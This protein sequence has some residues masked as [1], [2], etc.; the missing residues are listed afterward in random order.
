[1]KKPVKNVGTSVRTRLLKLAKERGED[2]QR[3]LLRYVNERLLY[4]LATSS[5]ASSFVLKG[6]ALFTVWTGRPH[7]ATRDLDFLGFGEATEARLRRVFSDVASMKTDDDGVVFDVRSLE[8]RPIREDQ[9]YGGT[10]VTLKA[11]VAEAQVRLQ[12]D[13]GFGDAVTPEAVEIEFPAL[14]SFPT[15]RLRAYPRETVVAEKLEA[16]V[17]LG[18]ANSRMKDFY[19]LAVL[20]E[21]FEF[22]GDL[23]VKAIRATF[24]RR[25]TP[26]PDGVPVA[27]SGDFT[28]DPAKARQWAGFASKS[29][30]TEAGNLSSAVRR[31]A[32]FVVVPLTRARSNERWPGRWPKGGPWSG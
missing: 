14:L 9:E 18:M 7:R 31:V 3:V 8:V 22:D 15:P 21:L 2:F 32:R 17:Q 4:R 19:D 5:H 30:V 29:G 26:L 20:S 16:M 6:A 13:I 27:L 28:G 25:G 12:V 24:S 10:R 23:L 1:M 11:G